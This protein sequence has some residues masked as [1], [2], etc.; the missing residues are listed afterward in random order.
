MRGPFRAALAVAVL[1]GVA[2]LIA[3]PIRHYVDHQSTYAPSQQQLAAAQRLV[4]Q[5]PTPAEA[6]RDL[7]STVCLAANTN[8][9]LTSTTR[10]PD[11]LFT[12]WSA[13]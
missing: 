3:P 5:L 12:M 10:S 2:A 4:S 9:C 11:A 13:S 7:Y 8:L 1:C 6:V